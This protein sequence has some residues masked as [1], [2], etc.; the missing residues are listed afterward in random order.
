MVPVPSRD[1]GIRDCTSSANGIWM[2]HA[3]VL[4]LASGQ[5]YVLSKSFGVLDKRLQLGDHLKVKAAFRPTNIYIP[6]GHI[7]SQVPTLHRARGFF[8]PSLQ[9]A[10]LTAGMGCPC[11]QPW[12]AARRG[13]QS[14][15]K[16]T[17]SPV[18]PPTSSAEQPTSVS[19]GHTR[20]SKNNCQRVLL[21][22]KIIKSGSAQATQVS[23]IT[24]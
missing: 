1:V 17:P 13:R 6:R 23:A 5:H 10:L 7:P 8:P 4:I 24:Q 22:S 2:D 9:A 20:A 11:D 14:F 19:A 12:G 18:I 21:Q 3:T 15:W 16:T